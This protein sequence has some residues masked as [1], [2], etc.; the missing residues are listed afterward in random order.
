MVEVSLIK[1]IVMHSDILSHMQAGD[2]I[3]ADK[4][5][6][7]SDMLP[8][9]VSLNIPPFLHHGKLTREECVL[10]RTIARARIH[11]ERAIQR[12]KGYRILGLIPHHYRANAT[13]IFMVC[14]ALVNLQNPILTE[15]VDM[16]SL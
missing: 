3:L 11:V 7:L 16:M 12:M 15:T 6:L 14:G 1:N 13:K 4:G 8:V 9:G 5:F 2:L 10:T